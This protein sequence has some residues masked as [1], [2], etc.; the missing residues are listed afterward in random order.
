MIT[1]HLQ[2]L[3]SFIQN[4]ISGLKITSFTLSCTL[5]MVSLNGD[6]IN[7]SF[8]KINILVIILKVRK[9][10]RAKCMT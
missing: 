10:V 1:I 2:I 6:V 9:L 7:Y 4:Y 5:L 3:F 8:S